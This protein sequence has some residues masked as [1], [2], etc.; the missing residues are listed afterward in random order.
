MR[1]FPQ[2]R[3]LS[4]RFLSIWEYA[5]EL[6]LAGLFCVLVLVWFDLRDL[7]RTL[8]KLR[9]DLLT[10]IGVALGISVAIWV[11]LLTILSSEFGTWLRK[12]G[13]AS[14]YSRALATPVLAY[15]LTFLL[16]LFTGCGDSR[17]VLV[18]NMFAT[19]YGLINLV[20]MIRNVQGVVGL[21]QTWQR[22]QK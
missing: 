9:T 2:A 20:T 4:R 15:V 7:L 8:C 3:S 18:L 14:A 11:G 1:P 22:K 13:E 6:I 5:G 17:Y 16:L 12:K 21:W 19:I 10:G